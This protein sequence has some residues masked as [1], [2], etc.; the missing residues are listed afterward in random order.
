MST[1]KVNNTPW[2]IGE[3]YLIRSVTKTN[4]GVLVQVYK[5]ELVLTDAAWIADTGRFAEALASSEFDEVEPY[6]KGRNVIIGR[7]AIEDAVIIDK[8]PLEQT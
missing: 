4:T 8:A 1:E 2:E 3:T 6:P 7:G 5:D